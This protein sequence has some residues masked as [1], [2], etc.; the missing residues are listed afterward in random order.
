MP[1]ISTA[2]PCSHHRHFTLIP[3][4][5]HLPLNV[6]DEHDNNP[7]ATL[8]VPQLTTTNSY[9]LRPRD[10]NLLI[11]PQKWVFIILFNPLHPKRFLALSKKWEKRLLPSSSLSVCLSFRPHRTTR[12]PMDGFSWNLIFEYFFL[13]N[14][15]KKLKFPYNPTII[16][17]PGSVSATLCVWNLEI[18]YSQTQLCHI[19]VFNG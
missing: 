12:L 5:C 13:E 11:V 15:S 14:L 10:L 16:T 19:G 3:Y 9:L 4:T 8:P 7:R 1:P 2:L 17:D 6:S 18:V